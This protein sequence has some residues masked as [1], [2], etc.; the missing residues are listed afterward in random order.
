[1]NPLSPDR[2][3]AAVAA[4]CAAVFFS[5]SC[6]ETV[7][8]RC[9]FDCGSWAEEDAAVV[10]DSSASPDTADGS[11]PDAAPP[12]DGATLPDAGKD[13]NAVEVVVPTDL[14]GG[15][16]VV[17]DTVVPPAEVV[18]D[19][20]ADAAPDVPQPQGP[21]E[22]RGIWVTR[23]DYDSAA[24]VADIMEEIASLGFN[25][26]MFQVR[27]NADAYYASNYEPWAKGLS[28]TLGKNPGWDPLEVA[29]NE[30]HAHG[31]EIHAWVNTFVAWTGTSP[32]P[33]SDPP[34]I[35]YAHPEWRQAD[36]NG[37]PMAWNNSYTWVSPGIPEVRQH[38]QD[39]VVDIVTGY[40]VD[41][42]HFDYIRYA[43][44][45]YSHDTWSEQAYAAAKASEPGLGYGDF[46]RDVLSGFVSDAYQALTAARPEV[47]VTASVWGIYQDSFG[48]GG[49]SEGYSDYFQDSHRWA[50]EG[51]IDAL[52]PM[53]YWPLTSPKGEW[54]D[55]ATLVDD[56]NGAKGDRHLYAGMKADY[57]TFEEIADEI[58]YTRTAGAEGFVVFSYATMKDAGYGDDFAATVN[59]EKAYPPPMPWK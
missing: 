14:P 2:T 52:C 33:Q 54:T 27:G 24:S 19:A 34:H 3:A 30:A 13:G 31:L 25:S 5:V 36:K 40:D 21:F 17:P 8:C 49:T 39:V 15:D 42:L 12:A 50:Q 6:S 10:E 45:D 7:K 18:A 35:L 55:F 43:G 32:P 22:F 29:V 28:G 56:H 57:A 51:Y 44:P 48:W 37:T 46:Q 38:I 20:A 58:A 9:Q 47:K 53:I 41:G 23:W 4:V 11:L 16:A 1:M 26:V 59:A